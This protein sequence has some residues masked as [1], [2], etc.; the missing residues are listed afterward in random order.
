M[1]GKKTGNALTVDALR[2]LHS[3]FA[4]KDTITK[5]EARDISVQSGA[6]LTQVRVRVRGVS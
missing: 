2:Y 4:V 6:T 5:K 1:A 3:V